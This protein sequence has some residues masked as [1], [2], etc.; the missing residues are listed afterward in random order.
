M[1]QLKKSHAAAL[2]TAFEALDRK[3]RDEL[4]DEL[5]QSGNDRFVDLAGSVHDEGDEAVAEELIDIENALIQRHVQKLRDL[6]D[7]R[8]RLEGGTIDECIEC[9][10]EIGYK[11]LLAY[12]S[13]LRCVQCQEVFDRTHMHEARPRL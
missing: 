1:N 3:L 7:A 2:T 12:P 8:K 13:A 9:G 10:G 6:E 4:R 11:R 5:K